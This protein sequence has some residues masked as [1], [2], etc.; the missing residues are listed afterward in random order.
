MLGLV[1]RT[2]TAAIG[3]PPLRLNPRSGTSAAR[4][5]GRSGAIRRHPQ[6]QQEQ[7]AEAD[8]PLVDLPFLLEEPEGRE[9]EPLGLLPHDEVQQ[10]RQ[11][12]QGG[13]GEQDRQAGDGEEGHGDMFSGAAIPP[14]RGHLRRRRLK[15]VC[16]GS[17]GH[18]LVYGATR[19][20]TMTSHSTG[21]PESAR[22]RRGSAAGSACREW[23]SAGRRRGSGR[24]WRRGPPARS[25]SSPGRRRSG[26]WSRTRCR[27]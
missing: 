9:R 7:V 11:P 24:P 25:G 27:P 15:T 17:A 21:G 2:M 23:P 13:P 5:T 18:R 8:L 1:S 26:R 19:G 20:D 6:E 14:A 22:R 10:D 3:R 4:A 12:D 16:T